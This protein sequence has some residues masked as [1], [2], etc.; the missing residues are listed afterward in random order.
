MPY[1]NCENTECVYC[2]Q[3]REC[4]YNS[5]IWVGDVYCAGCSEY[6]SY[7]N[8]EDYQ[9]EFWKTYPIRGQEGKYERKKAIGKRIEINGREFF[10]EDN[11][12]YDEKNMRVTDGET[13]AFCGYISS[14]KENWEK[15][16]K[17]IGEI[18]KNNFSNVL[19][20]PIKEEN[21]QSDE[22]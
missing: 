21:K 12:N 13:G 2:S 11:P 16:I 9:T 18:K 20:L 22:I 17:Q 19:E 4:L 3:N 10:T 14:V 1:V 15:L 7:R 5:N 8:T 6:S